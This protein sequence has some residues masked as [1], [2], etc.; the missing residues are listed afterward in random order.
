M[1]SLLITCA[2]LCVT[3]TAMLTGTIKTPN[4]VN[5]HC[6]HI[7][8]MPCADLTIHCHGFPT[9]LHVKYSLEHLLCKST[10]MLLC[11]VYC[12][13]TFFSVKATAH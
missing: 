6:S 4:N 7:A 8:S 3:R 2:Q 9:S 10:L 1:L 5:G 13:F 11:I 12:P